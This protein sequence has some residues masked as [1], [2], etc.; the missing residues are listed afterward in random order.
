MIINVP[1]KIPKGLYAAASFISPWKKDKTD[2]VDPQA[3]QGTPVIYLKKQN[4]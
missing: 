3:G 1:L 4:T 2:R